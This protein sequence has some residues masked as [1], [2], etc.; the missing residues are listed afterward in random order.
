MIAINLVYHEILICISFFVTQS[1]TKVWTEWGALD[2][3]DAGEIVLTYVINSRL[4][5]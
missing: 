5:H 2:L 4:F 1:V 3:L